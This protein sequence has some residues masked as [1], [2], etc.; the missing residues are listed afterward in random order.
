[1]E[2]LHEDQS[3]ILTI[4]RSF[5]LTMRNVSDKNCGGNQNTHF[6][7]SNFFKNRTVF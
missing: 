1:M 7:F 6:T 3:T 2:T 5:L 4:S